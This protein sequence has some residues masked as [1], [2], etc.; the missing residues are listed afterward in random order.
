MS[1]KNLPIKIVLQKATDTQKNQGGGSTKF[2]G[3]VTQELQNELAEKFENILEFYED[4][5]KKN[6]MVP[7][8]GKITVKPE[9]IAKSH[10]PNDLCRNCQIIGGEDLD[11]IY[12]KVT[13]K[14]IAD[15]VALIQNPPSE[16]VKANLTAITDI[17]PITATEKISDELKVISA[18]GNFD[19]IKNKIKIKLF[20]FNDEF[21]NAQILGYIMREL[22]SLGFMDKHELI[23]YGENIK[24]IKVEVSSYGDVVKLA[25][26]NGVKSV[27]FFQEY[28]LPLSEFANTD[29]QALL[30]DGYSDSD[31]CIG[32]ID[33]G[34]SDSNKFLKPYI[35]EREEYV[36]EIYRNYNHATFIASTIQYGNRLNGIEALN[37]QRFKFIDVIAI[38]NGDPKFGLTDTRSE[39]ELMEIIEEIM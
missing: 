18:Q 5:F 25:S 27:D 8:V 13:R 28:S 9:A 12:I 4:V 19:T 35:I 1:K 30:D 39:D 33:G 3:E 6:E 31:I 38:P 23:T 29:L 24:F 15:T 14:S 2:F 32:I 20:D 17:Q 37:Q 7:A 26:I 22:T 34:I 16:K 36:N 21:D 10:K 11:E